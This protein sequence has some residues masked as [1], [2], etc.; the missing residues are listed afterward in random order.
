VKQ[1]AVAFLIVIHLL[2]SV[3]IAVSSHYCAGKVTSVK[4]SILAEHKCPCGKKPMKKDC[5][6][7]EAK[8]F[9][10]KNEQQKADQFSLTVFKADMLR[11]VFTDVCKLC[12]PQPLA[13]NK[14]LSF[15]HPPDN[16]K[17]PLYIQQRV[18]RI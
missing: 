8:T 5:C 6:R 12:S 1:T 2:F 7:E 13:L 4:L 3:G 14:Y 9:K 11:P 17:H 15:G 16:T 18:F 10:L